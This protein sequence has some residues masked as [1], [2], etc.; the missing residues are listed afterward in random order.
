M[1]VKLLAGLVGI[2]SASCLWAFYGVPLGPFPRS[3]RDE[4]LPPATRVSYRQHERQRRSE[5]SVGRPHLMGLISL[6]RV[7]FDESTQVVALKSPIASGTSP[8]QVQIAEGQTGFTHETV[9]MTAF[10]SFAPLC[11]RVKTA[12][13][14]DP[15]F[16][17]ARQTH[18]RT[19]ETFVGSAG[20]G[21]SRVINISP[22]REYHQ[23]TDSIANVELVSLLVHEKPGAYLIKHGPVPVERRPLDSFEEL[24]LD[25][26]RL[27]ANL[28][29]S[30]E[31][32]QR[33][34]GAIRASASCLDCHTGARENDLLGAFTYLLKTPVVQLTAIASK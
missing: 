27:G 12:S 22:R 4:L 10:T 24:A 25:R 14:T 2:I 13:D 3:E 15:R 17:A 7:P 30:P 21:I 29:W 19:T 8:F 31:H 33:M 6:N 5:S 23:N 1:Y 34:F 9:P 11:Q 20:F 16:L 18:A 28:V 32:P 26:V